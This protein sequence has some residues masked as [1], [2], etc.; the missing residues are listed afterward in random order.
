LVRH[1]ALTRGAA[2]SEQ[3]TT[4]MSA[5]CIRPFVG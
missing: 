3:R 4:A 2:N 1:C 5:E